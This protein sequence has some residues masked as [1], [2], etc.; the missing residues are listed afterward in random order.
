MNA[1]ELTAVRCQQVDLSIGEGPVGGDEE[2][3]QGGAGACEVCETSGA[4]LQRSTPGG[5][6]R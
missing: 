6:T 2:F 4:A 5:E 1:P 3:A